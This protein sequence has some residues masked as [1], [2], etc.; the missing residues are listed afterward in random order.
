MTRE[1]LIQHCL[2][3]VSPLEKWGEN[4]GSGHTELGRCI[5]YLMAGCPFAT[6]ESP[7]GRWLY[8]TLTYLSF[9]NA[10]NGEPPSAKETLG[11]PSPKYLADCKACGADWAV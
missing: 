3:A 2:S 11:V 7:D 1:E 6:E 5:A 4:S 9:R 8:V 10:E